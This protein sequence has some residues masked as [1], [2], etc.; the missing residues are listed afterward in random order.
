[1]ALSGE[2][3]AALGRLCGAL[4]RT[5]SL[6]AGHIGLAADGR[7]DL[8]QL[9]GAHCNGQ[10]RR[11]DASK[12]QSFHKAGRLLPAE[13][14][15]GDPQPE[16]EI[17]PVRWSIDQEAVWLCASDNRG[18]FSAHTKDLPHVWSRRDCQFVLSASIR[19]RIRCQLRHRRP[20][21]SGR[22][23]FLWAAWLEASP[24]AP[25]AVWQNVE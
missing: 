17:V 21:T 6:G 20:A 8:D 25:P 16:K 3:E 7:A 4:L 5:V 19:S 15:P 13:R 10:F 14:L 24:Q 22:S 2:I 18:G 1:M 12:L 23:A 9:P 11:Q